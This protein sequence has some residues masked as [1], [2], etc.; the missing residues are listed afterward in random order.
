VAR[1]RADDNTD[2]SFKYIG[3]GFCRDADDK[4][5][6]LAEIQCGTD[7]PA[8]QEKCKAT[9]K[10]VGISWTNDDEFCFDTDGNLEPQ[11][12]VYYGD[13]TPEVPIPVENSRVSVFD[14]RYTCFAYQ[15]EKPTMGCMVK[16]EKKYGYNDCGTLTKEK[17]CAPEVLCEWKDN[18][19]KCAHV[20]DGKEKKQCKKPTFQGKKICKFKK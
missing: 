8:C 5:P 7:L 4:N 3:D 18:N 6:W 19:N 10:C 13:I 20:C 12:V 16:K 17:K 1:I 11:C 14:E 2:S 9:D 15:P